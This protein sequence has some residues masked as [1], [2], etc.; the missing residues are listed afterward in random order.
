MYGEFALGTTVLIELSELGEIQRC[1]PQAAG[2]GNTEQ[3]ERPAAAIDD[4]VD[5]VVQ[6]GADARP[7]DG[8]TSTMVPCK[9]QSFAATSK[10]VGRKV[11]VVSITRSTRRPRMLS[12]GPVMPASVSFEHL[13][14]G[15]PAHSGSTG[16]FQE[17]DYIQGLDKVCRSRKM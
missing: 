17:A 10:W 6:V 8:S 12:I 5:V 13:Y 3:V 7:V 14:S 4:V 15:Q 1:H 11:R 2:G 9:R 16:R